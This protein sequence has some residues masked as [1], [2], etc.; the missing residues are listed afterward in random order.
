M[1]WSSSLGTV[2]Y[3]DRAHV[4]A[5][6]AS[7]GATVFSGDKLSTEQSGGVQVRASAARLLLPGASGAVL[8]SGQRHASRNADGR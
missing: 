2:V 6:K 7:V 1:R 5:G 8:S 3:A 4:G